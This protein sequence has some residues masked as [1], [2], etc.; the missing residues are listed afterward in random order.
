MKVRTMT[1]LLAILGGAFL[2]V[3]AGLNARL[4]TALGSA[5]KAVG[6]TSLVT[7][8]MAFAFLMTVERGGSPMA[9]KVTWY[10]WLGG[11]F[12]FLGVLVYFTAIPKIGI[13]NMIALGL[14]GQVLFGLLAGHFGWLGAPVSP[15]TGT[16]IIGA[17]ALLLGTILI[18]RQ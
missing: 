12:S 15:L 10:L 11:V 3:Q 13:S 1:V 9:G 16:K 2:A 8:L 17:M 14:T 7:S 18:T 4:G 5:V 6:V